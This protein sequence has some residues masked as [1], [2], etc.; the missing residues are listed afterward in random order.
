VV[1]VSVA[2]PSNVVTAVIVTWVGDIAIVGVP[3]IVPVTVSKVSPAGSA[4]CTENVVPVAPVAVVDVV[5]GSIALPTVALA[6]VTDAVTSIGVVNVERAAVGVPAPAELMATAVIE[7]SVPGERPVTNTGEVMADAS[8]DTVPIDPD[9]TGETVTVYES[10]SAPPVNVAAPIVT[11]AVVADVALPETDAGA[12]G[13]SGTTSNVNVVVPVEVAPPA[14]VDVAVIVNVVA[15]N[16][17]VGVSEIVPVEASKVSPAGSVG[18]MEY[19][20]PVGAAAEIEVEIGV[21][22]VPTVAVRVETDVVTSS[23]VVNVEDVDVDPA[24]LL[25]AAVVVTEYVVPGAR[26][27]GVIVV[28]VDVSVTA[29]PPPRGVSVAEYSVIAAPPVDVGAVTE[30][31]AAVADVAAAE[32]IE[33]AE[34]GAAGVVIVDVAA[35]VAPSPTALVA[36]VVIAYVVPGA[37]PLIVTALEISAAGTVTRIGVPP[38]VGVAI[39]SY[40]IIVD[41]PVTVAAPIVTDADVAVAAVADTEAGAPGTVAGVTAAE[42]TDAAEPPLMLFATTLYV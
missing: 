10:I 37:K 26:L 28:V 14:T 42:A 20:V 40:S 27:V 2:P 31:V 34:G 25:L 7:Y 21:I 30:I 35:V 17:A 39:I 18:L 5:I 23:G 36:R 16:A 19:V 38:S 29:A 22:S 8:G 3:E 24:P 9:K 11:L 32:V 1:P 6:V 15:L 33:G 12:P 13:A 41:P 4:A